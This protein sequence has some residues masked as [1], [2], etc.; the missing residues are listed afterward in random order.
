M[1]KCKEQGLKI[2]LYPHNL[3][4]I[5]LTDTPRQLYLRGQGLD[6]E[7]DPANKLPMGAADEDEPLYEDADDEDYNPEEERA[8]VTLK[9]TNAPNTWQR[10]IFERLTTIETAVQELSV[11][12]QVF[13]ERFQA[14]EQRS[15]GD[16]YDVMT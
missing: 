12:H 9:P 16:M 6:D 2:P 10:S 13:D 3:F 11:D 4:D 8:E 1:Q 15:H 7:V 5:D 14:F